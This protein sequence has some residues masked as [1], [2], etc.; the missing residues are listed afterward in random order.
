[1]NI[2]R[3]REIVSELWDMGEAEEGGL[4]VEARRGHGEREIVIRGDTAG[5][6][7]FARMVLD[8]ASKPAGRFHT[9]ID[10]TSI[11]DPSDVDLVVA[12]GDRSA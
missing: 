9:H 2:E 6:V 4:F 11:L 10:G 12:Y 3:L 7:E 5:L 8:I 1:M